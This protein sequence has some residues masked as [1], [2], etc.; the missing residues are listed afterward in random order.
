LP[1]NF[2]RID[3]STP[4]PGLRKPDDMKRICKKHSGAFQCLLFDADTNP[5]SA[6]VL[7]K[8]GNVGAN[9]CRTRRRRDDLPVLRAPRD[10]VTLD[11]A[12]LRSPAEPLLPAG[13]AAAAEVRS[14]PRSEKARNSTTFLRQASLMVATKESPPVL[15]VPAG[16]RARLPRRLPVHP[17]CDPRG[18]DELAR[19]VVPRVPVGEPFRAGCAS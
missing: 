10:E 15:A 19:P 17:I 12:R 14:L 7:V 1:H 18:V 11:H 6:Y 13:A 9:P 3:A 2:I 4:N 8:D 16:C 5:Q